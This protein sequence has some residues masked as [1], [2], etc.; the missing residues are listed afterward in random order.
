MTRRQ[1]AR[2]M[3]AAQYLVLLVAV[4]ALVALAD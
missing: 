2:A 1:R 3:R 4:G